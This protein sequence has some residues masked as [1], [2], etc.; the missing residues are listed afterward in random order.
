MQREEFRNGD[1][2]P[3]QRFTAQLNPFVGSLK[4]RQE[5]LGSHDLTAWWA[6]LL[7]T[8]GAI[9]Q[10]FEKYSCGSLFA[11]RHMRRLIPL[12]RVYL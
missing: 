11:K 7:A 6:I 4:L 10:H 2:G 1:A 8:S 9:R 12:L 5:N 3:A